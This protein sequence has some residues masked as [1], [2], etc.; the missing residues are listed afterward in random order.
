MTDL[1][2]F[3]DSQGLE[4]LEFVSVN[5]LLSPSH[6]KLTTLLIGSFTLE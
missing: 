2:I 1:S 5:N 4:S 6:S 3:I